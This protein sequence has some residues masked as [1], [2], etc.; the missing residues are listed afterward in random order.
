MR[1]EEVESADEG[2]EHVWYITLS[3]LEPEVPEGSA[4]RSISS[5]LFPSLKREYKRSPSGNPPGR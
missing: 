2:D 1:L 4:A 5:A 3:I